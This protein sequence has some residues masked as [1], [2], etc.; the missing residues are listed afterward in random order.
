MSVELPAP[1]PPSSSPWQRLYAAVLERRRRG[2]QT[3]QRHL[4][5]PVLSIGNL[6]WGGTG[7]TPTVQAL[8]RHLTAAGRRVAVL[9]RGYGRRSRGMVVVSRGRGPEVDVATAG[10]EPHLLARSIPDLVVAVG[11]DRHAAGLF[12]LDRVDP[13]IELFLLDDG[14]AHLRLARDLDLLLFPLRDPWGGGR[15]LP[16][17]RLREPLEATRHADAVLLTAAAS[18]DGGPALARH[19]RPFGFS[20]PGFACAL[21]TELAS[22]PRG[23]VV[24]VSAVAS[25]DRIRR[26]AAEH[27][28]E[29]AEHLAYADHHPYPPAS[30]QAIDEAVRRHRAEAVVTTSKD[31]GK[32]SG[33]LRAPL[34]ELTARLSLP[35]TFWAWLG[36]RLSRVEAQL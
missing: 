33:R 34:I 27:G 35:D 11:R 23:R 31:L 7:K 4:P 28:L 25:P 24:L 1:P 12:V 16:S 26:S 2:W 9:S 20:G 18:A 8:A 21:E 5:R 22:T 32:L 15:L 17:G 3:K 14:F 13:S 36:A 29:V 10:D 6:H 30:L 19:L